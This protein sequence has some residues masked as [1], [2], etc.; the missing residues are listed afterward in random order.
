MIK[1]LYSL[2]VLKVY[3]LFQNERA[4]IT[5]PDQSRITLYPI[6]LVKSAE[7]FISWFY[8]GLQVSHHSSFPIQHVRASVSPLWILPHRDIIHSLVGKKPENKLLYI[9]ES[10][11]WGVFTVSGGALGAP[12]KFKVILWLRR[13]ISVWLSTLTTS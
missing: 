12:L 13:F 6:M 10:S 5:V 4:K 9:P 1:I 11:S 7:K 8:S 3:I 2:K